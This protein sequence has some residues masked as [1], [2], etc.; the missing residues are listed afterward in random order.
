MIWLDLLLRRLIRSIFEIQ[1]LHKIGEW[2]ARR[3]RITIAII[4]LLTQIYP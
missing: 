1:A 3:P 4:L 2:I